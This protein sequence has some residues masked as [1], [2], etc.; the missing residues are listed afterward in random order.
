MNEITVVVPISPIP[1]HPDLSILEQTVESIRHHLSD[2]ELMLCFDGVRPEQEHRRADYEEHIRQV[3]WK[4]D[5]DPVWRP[6]CPWVFDDHKHQV[7]MLRSVLDEVRTPLM[8]FCEQDTP[9]V[10]DEPIDWQACIELI[11]REEAD[12]VRFAHEAHVLEAHAHM[13]HGQ[14]DGFMRTSQ[15]SARPHLAAVDYYDRILKDHFSSDANT[16]VEDVMHSVCSEAYIINGMDGWGQHRLWIYHPDGG[17]IKRS[18]H[19]DGRAG[20]PKF[21]SLLRF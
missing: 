19:I 3:L 4:A 14:V 18:V 2:A 6:M 11:M 1:S 7:G 9:L 8:L 20:D 16:F 13:V 5:H 12:V 10:T 17:N 21:D 15:F